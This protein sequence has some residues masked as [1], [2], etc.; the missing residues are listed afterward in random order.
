MGLVLLTG[1]TSPFLRGGPRFLLLCLPLLFRSAR[2]RGL[3]G[4]SRR[5]ARFE[6]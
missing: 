5:F 1:N 2:C 3:G 6:A 4:N